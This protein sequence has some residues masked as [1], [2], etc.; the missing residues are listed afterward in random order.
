[1]VEQLTYKKKQYPIRISY[2]VIKGMKTE[3]GEADLEKI[4]SLD[5]KIL[6]TMLWFS[7]VSGHAFE[8][9]ELTLK[10]EDME[11]FLDQNFMEFISLIPKFFPRAKMGNALAGLGVQKETS[12]Q[13]SQAEENQ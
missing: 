13:Q 3:L 6:E 11:D 4:G 1:M 12:A 7:L 5:P 8:E 2:R 10:K 9:K